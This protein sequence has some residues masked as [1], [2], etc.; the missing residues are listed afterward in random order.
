[1]VPNPTRAA[2]QAWVALPNAAS[3]ASVSPLPRRSRRGERSSARERIQI[4]FSPTWCR[5]FFAN[6]GVCNE[7]TLPRFDRERELYAAGHLAEWKVAL[8]NPDRTRMIEILESVDL[9][10]QAASIVDSV[11]AKPEFN[12]FSSPEPDR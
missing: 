2:W 4:R 12:G 6:E 1:M 5:E 3:A 9:K 10:E 8:R 11:L 7:I